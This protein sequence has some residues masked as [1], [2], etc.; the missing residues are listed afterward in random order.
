MDQSKHNLRLI[1][2]AFFIAFGSLTT[3]AQKKTPNTQ[4]TPTQTATIQTTIQTT[5]QTSR[6]IHPNQVSELQGTS[7]EGSP[8]QVLNRGGTLD[9]GTAHDDFLHADPSG[10]DNHGQSNNTSGCPMMYTEVRI[11]FLQSCISSVA[12]VDYY[13][14]GNVLA[15]G[16]YVDI[17]FPVELTLDS[18]SLPYTII[19]TDL[20]RFQLGN[21]AANS[22][23]VFALHFTTACDSALLGEE[24][25]IN[26]HIYPDT[27]CDAVH[28]DFL[29]TVDGACIN[30]KAKFT[31]QNHGIAITR[32]QHLQLIVIEDHFLAGGTPYYIEEDTLDIDKDTTK[33]LGISSLNA[34]FS[35]YVLKIKDPSGTL[36]A[37]SHVKDCSASLTNS[38]VTNLHPNQY[39]NGTH[40]PFLA[41]G[42]ATNGASISQ[43]SVSMNQSSL[44]GNDNS[45]SNNG[46]NQNIMKTELGLTQQTTVRIFPN[47]FDLFTTVKIDGSISD[48][49]SF[50]LYDVTGKT[51]QHLDLYKQKEF[52]LER[53]ELLDGM[54]FYQIESE[55]TTVGTGKVIIK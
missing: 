34:A 42:C 33:G 28:D 38:T 19:G 12:Y 54:Y 6:L 7:M 14:H 55:G 52:K 41:E 13:N 15:V 24:H 48:K 51:V 26:A 8:H 4:T 21:I 17:E 31:I 40:L 22:S 5:T 44:N 30:G 50:R 29:L 43:G 53:K 16:A 1:V 36:L 27:I 47:P 39:S 45:S 20:Y 3:F 23:N 32:D 18:A 2:A 37:K 25:C 49:F 46:N 9:P 35:S 10:N 11:P